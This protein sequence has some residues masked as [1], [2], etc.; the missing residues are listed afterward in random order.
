[1]NTNYNILY[2]EHLIYGFHVCTC[3]FLLYQESFNMIL[4]NN[5]SFSDGGVTVG[6]RVMLKLSTR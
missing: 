1:M 4:I 5:P 3:V 2:S 6:I